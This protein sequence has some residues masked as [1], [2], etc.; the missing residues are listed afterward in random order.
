MDVMENAVSLL[1]PSQPGR[2]NTKY[3]DCVLLHGRQLKAIST[4][5]VVFA[6][7]DPSVLASIP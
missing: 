3:L 4:D 1:L 5:G 2:C 6:E 7:H